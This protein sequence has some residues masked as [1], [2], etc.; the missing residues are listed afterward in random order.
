MLERELEIAK[1]VVY[2]A[3]Q[4]IQCIADE[5]YSTAVDKVDRSIV[6]LADLEAD[7]ILKDKLI[8]EFD[9]YGWLSEET[10]SDDSRLDHEHV[11]IIDPIDG[12]R[13][14]VMQNPE[15]VVSVALAE[16]DRIVLGIIYNPS[17]GDIYEAVRGE[18]AKLNGRTIRCNHV[19][20]SPPV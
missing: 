16:E 10:K 9:G 3:G 14:F 15:F 2:E 18:G 19:L 8:G 5:H 6:T 1:E 12:T 11:W 17:T 4:A 13:E 7:R 20:G